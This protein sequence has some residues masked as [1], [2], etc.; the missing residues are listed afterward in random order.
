MVDRVIVPVPGI[1]TLALSVDA[2]Q[3][4]LAEGALLC[5]SPAPAA[6]ATDEVL[7]V[8]SEEIARRTDTAASWWESAARDSDCPS[9][10]V[11]RVRRFDVKACMRW[12]TDSQERD[13][14]GRVRRCAVA[15]RARD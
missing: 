1:G 13:G 10:F 11:G 2:Y 6:A 4:A 12:L 9:L 15:P 8:S 14:A 5:A 3:Q 7:L